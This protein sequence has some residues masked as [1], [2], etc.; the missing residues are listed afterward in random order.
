MVK[1]RKLLCT[2]EIL[3]WIWQI[4]SMCMHPGTRGASP[5]PNTIPVSTFPKIQAIFTFCYC[6]VHSEAHQ[7]ALGLS[8]C[9]TYSTFHLRI[10]HSELPVSD[11]PKSSCTIR[12]THMECFAFLLYNRT[13]THTKPTTE[14]IGHELACCFR[15]T[16]FF[17]S[18]VT[19]I[20]QTGFPC[21]SM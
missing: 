7:G 15:K 12:L 4:S 1:Y 8:N 11:S 9:N 13:P 10:V 19:L 16:I 21:R 14:L 18:T 20:F 5:A 3:D 2:F 6:I 17:I